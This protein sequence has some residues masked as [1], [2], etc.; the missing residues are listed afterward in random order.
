MLRT[1]MTREKRDRRCS[2]PRCKDALGATRASEA[3]HCAMEPP[4][5]AALA[6]QTRWRVA[7]PK[8]LVPSLKSTEGATRTPSQSQNVHYPLPRL[9]IPTAI[10][11]P[12]LRM[13]L[14]APVLPSQPL[15]L[16]CL[17]LLCCLV[18]GHYARNAR[19][20]LAPLIGRHQRVR[21]AQ[22]RTTGTALAAAAP[23]RNAG[24]RAA[25]KCPAS[26]RLVCSL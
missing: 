26:Y 12:L 17:E 8:L 13:S 18:A 10:Q 24:R 19:R 20:I 16:D 25:S 3:G 22:T 14:V 11:M 6:P 5:G 21:A 4:R 7:A 1:S 23:T 9:D 2:F 15:L